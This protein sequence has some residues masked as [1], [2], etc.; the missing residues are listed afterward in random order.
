MDFDEFQTWWDKEGGKNAKAREASGVIELDKMQ[1]ITGSGVV[2]IMV[3][4]QDC[5]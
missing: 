3:A 1:T 5:F 2:D 4:S